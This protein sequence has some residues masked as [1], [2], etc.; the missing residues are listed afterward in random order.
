[1]AASRVF[2]FGYLLRRFSHSQLLWHGVYLDNFLEEKELKVSVCTVTYNR[3][4]W[5]QE[6][7]DSVL[8]QKGVEWEYIIIDNGSNH[9]S[10]TTEV[11]SKYVDDPRF[12]LF[13]R[14]ENCVDSACKTCKPPAEFAVGDYITH[15]PDDDFLVGNDSLLRRAQVLE[16]D[17]KIGFVFSAVLGHNEEGFS[18]GLQGM[19]HVSSEDV[20]SS[21]AA[22]DALFVQCFTPY[23]SVVYRRECYS[24]TRAAHVLAMGC[25]EDWGGWVEISRGYNT[26][27]LAS[28]TVS[29]RQ[30]P[31]QDTNVRGFNEGQFHKANM[32]LWG[33]YIRLGYRPTDAQWS[34]MWAITRNLLDR[35]TLRRRTQ[36]RIEIMRLHEEAHK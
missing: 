27:Y 36:T 33:H 3:A 22:F 26:A 29:L 2:V 10:G 25:A 5:L 34:E 35:E 16:A 15:L 18:L 28:P 8:M 1:M 24:R 12:K 9:D 30:H 32:T 4:E 14:S 31:L 23:P 21:A 17:S 20:M 11:M 7:I 13:Y 6:T 19:G